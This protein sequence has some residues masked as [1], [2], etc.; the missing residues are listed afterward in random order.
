MLAVSFNDRTELLSLPRLE[1]LLVIEESSIDV[2]RYSNNNVVIMDENEELR[3]YDITSGECVF[4]LEA[5]SGTYTVTNDGIVAFIQSDGI[6]RHYN[7][8]GTVTDVSTPPGLM[9][10]RSVFSNDGSVLIGT[11]PGGIEILKTRTG[12]LVQDVVLNDP[13]LGFIFRMATS[14]SVGN[15]DFIAVNDF[16]ILFIINVVTGEVIRRDGAGSSAIFSKDGTVIAYKTGRE[17]QTTF[18]SVTDGRVLQTVNLNVSS[19]FNGFHIVGFDEDYIVIVDR[20]GHRI[21]AF[22]RSL[23]FIEYEFT[24]RS[25]RNNVDAFY[26]EGSVVLM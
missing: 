25:V 12:A 13:A 22:S 24:S 19:V 1:L 5:E 7:F 15:S 4:R 3:V 17:T 18:M 16:G 10:T 21:A 23:D 11:V 8:D 20:T 26:P 2:V 6:I 9:L 14:I